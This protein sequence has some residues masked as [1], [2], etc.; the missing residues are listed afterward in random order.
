MIGT[1]GAYWRSR[2]GK[3]FHFSH[4]LDEGT[5]FHLG[6][7][8]HRSPEA[9]IETF[10][11]TWLSWAGPC[12][13]LYLDPAGEFVSKKWL[14]MTQKEDIKISMTAT[15]SHWQIGRVEIHGNIITTDCIA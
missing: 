3:S 5:L 7:R 14:T 12:K 11:N 4:F 2:E 13:Q 15:E 8:T 9:Q 10:E 1:D 6:K